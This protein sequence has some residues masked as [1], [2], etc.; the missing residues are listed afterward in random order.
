MTYGAGATIK[1]LNGNDPSA[2]TCQAVGEVRFS[3][4]N[5][6]VQR[7]EYTLRWNRFSADRI[8]ACRSETL[9]DVQAAIRRDRSGQGS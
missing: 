8:F 5:V 6:P 9:E 2:L 3:P 4:A 1:F 7:Q